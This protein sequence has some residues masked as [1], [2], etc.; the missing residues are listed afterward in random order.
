MASERDRQKAA[1]AA[2]AA[3]MVE[4]GMRLGLGSGSTAA[5]VVRA[6][7]PRVRAGMKLARVVSSSSAT[8]RL[9]EAEGIS[10][11]SLDAAPLDLVI[12]G[13]DEVDPALRMIKGGGGA[14]LRE[15]VLAHAAERVVIVV[16][17]PKQV[18]TLGRFPLPLEVLPF[19]TSFVLRTLADLS[20]RVRLAADGREART[21]QDNALVDCSIGRIDDP[22][23]LAQR[24]AAIPGVIEHGLFLDEADLVVIGQ[25]EGVRV[26][27]RP[28][29][30]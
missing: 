4:A 10:V 15:K 24:L 28:R 9:A 25:D 26:V 6:L 3:A 12:D 27:S 11:E 30:A 23:A 1:A 16:D 13:A 2:Y 29:R 19:A 20:P 22:E 7:G 14:L 17:G 5:H 21:D 18:E 8:T